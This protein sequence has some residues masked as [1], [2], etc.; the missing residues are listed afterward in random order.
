VEPSAE[1]MAWYLASH[2][3]K[4]ADVATYALQHDLTFSDATWALY[5]TMHAKESADT[6]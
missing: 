1:Q 2:G 3:M 4:Y 6:H 5:Q